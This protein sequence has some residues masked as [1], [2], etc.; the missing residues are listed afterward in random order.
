MGCGSSSVSDA[1]TVPNQHRQAWADNLHDEGHKT[2]NRHDISLQRNIQGIKEYDNRDI[3]EDGLSKNGTKVNDT[4][5]H[6]ISKHSKIE[7]DIILIDD[8]RG[9]TPSSDELLKFTE[10]K[11]LD[12]NNN[13]QG[14]LKGADV[15]KKK[16]SEKEIN[17]TKAKKK[18]TEGNKVNRD[19][20]TVSPSKNVSRK[21]K[22]IKPSNV[23]SNT[24]RHRSNQKT[25][26]SSIP[27]PKW[28]HNYDIPAVNPTEGLTEGLP[29]I[30]EGLDR[31]IK[32]EDTFWSGKKKLIPDMEVMRK[33]DNHALKA[34]KNIKTDVS[35][36]V[37]YLIKPASNDLQ[38]YRAIVRW[39]SDNIA[40]DVDVFFNR[41]TP[42]SS[43]PMEALKKGAAVCAGYSSLFQL[44]CNMGAYL[45]SRFTAMEI[46]CG[47]VAAEPG[48]GLGGL[49]PPN[50]KVEGANA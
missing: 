38:K 45:A 15:A 8:L 24:P 36:L 12:E 19:K 3:Y 11:K 26:T 21:Q 42:L 30:Y 23:K 31:P 46:A 40:Y 27:Q 50:K 1:S 22:Q 5:L 49:S 29:H 34:P 48:G 37:T 4:S 14:K 9:E 41:N 25:F 13:L 33:I 2:G 18:Q 39:I 44:M 17:K 7:G 35:K 28:R 10:E 43:D 6:G 16:N 32:I 47:A 20:L